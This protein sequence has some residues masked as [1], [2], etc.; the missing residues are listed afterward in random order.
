M[1]ILSHSLLNNK[2]HPLL[3]NKSL[4]LLNI[5]RDLIFLFI[6]YQYL[7]CLYPL[8]NIKPSSLLNTK[9]SCLL[10]TNDRINANSM[11][12]LLGL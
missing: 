12:I 11:P 3:N 8:L 1:L 6:K 5:N 4:P 7:Y 10:N 2:F 9:S